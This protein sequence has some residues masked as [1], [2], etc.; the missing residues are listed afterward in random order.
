MSRLADPSL[1]AALMLL[2]AII[3]GYAGALVR[4]P[5]VVG[6]LVG[7][8]VLQYL[9]GY[10]EV[11]FTGSADEHFLTSS[12]NDLHG[13][14]TLALGLIMFSIG[15][16]FEARHFRAIA[17]R[18]LP[19]SLAKL[20]CV[21]VLTGGGCAA[22]AL[23]TS[24]LSTAA[25]ISLG[26]L[27]G[28][29]GIATA[30][31]A[32]LMVLR[33][34]E[35]KG[36]N[37][38]AVL[39]MTAMNNVVCIVLFHVAFMV[40]T[41]TGLIESSFGEGRWL[42]LDLLLTSIG[43]AALGVVIGFVF[44]VIY[45]R[46]TIADF[47]LIFLGVLMLLGVFRD[48]LAETLHL[49]YSFLLTSLFIGATFANIT[50]DQQPFH[51]ALRSFSG[52]IFS[53]F[54]VMAG[55]ELHIDELAHAKMLGLGYIVFRIAGKLLGAWWG[56]RRTQHAEYVAELG[57]GMLC[58]AGVAI[59]LATFVESTWGA[60][61]DGV[62]KPHPAAKMFQTVVFGSVVIFELF[63]PI[64]LKRLAIVSGEVKAVT[65][66]RRRRTPGEA[67]ESIL[68]AAWDAV[69]GILAPPEKS[70][71]RDVETLRVKHIMRANVKV[72]QSSS[73]FDD[74][75][76]FVEKSKHNHFPVVNEEGAYVGMIHYGDLRNIIYAPHFRD[77]VTAIDLARS[78]SPTTTRDAPLREVLDVFHGADLG[79]MAVLEAGDSR[80]VVGILEQ[81]DLLLA[82]RVDAR[83][84]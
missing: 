74:V 14:Q 73:S 49:S 38:D 58:Q 25:A 36:P 29:V 52:P 8:V 72:L 17:P 75:L 57:V 39:T 6:Y 68:R 7:G 66:L 1:L 48:T 84:K 28:T 30:P 51:N 12:V 65:L 33:E 9:L 59:G 63:G 27:F 35:A 82:L 46:L 10:V 42:W 67:R 26:L 55:F 34:Y 69:V 70:K 56:A 77:L 62:F 40:L 43:S 11:R 4:V 44:S 83:P 2:T 19:I 16:V 80:R 76:S 61:V 50:P 54:F 22:I 64:A 21:F 78:D 31:A 45:V 37:S 18:L 79:C 13:I 23:L 47:M 15:D 24:E 60:D 32:T 81:R 20:V 5:R 3:G 71:K 53:L 41:Y